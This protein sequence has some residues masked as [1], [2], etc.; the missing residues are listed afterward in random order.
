MKN[1]YYKKIWATANKHI[2]N[3]NMLLSKRPDIYLSDLW[4]T[5]YSKAKGCAV[6]DLK[7]K[8]FFDLSMM[9][10]GTNV[11]GYSN[12]EI[13]KEVK[14]AVDESNMSTLNSF[15]EVEG[16]KGIQGSKSNIQAR[17]SYGGLSIR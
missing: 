17:I 11:L 14:K 10:V 16:Y 6:W 7:G 3:G 12:S 13:N 15:H 5:Y 2:E 1:N 9:G 4:P 8:K